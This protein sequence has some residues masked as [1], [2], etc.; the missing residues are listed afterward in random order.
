MPNPYA[1][2]NCGKTNDR[3]PRPYCSKCLWKM[4]RCEVGKCPTLIIGA[5]TICRFHRR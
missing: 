4:H 2:I 1:C 5:E 3:S